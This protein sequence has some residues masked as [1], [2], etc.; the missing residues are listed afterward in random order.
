MLRKSCHSLTGSCDV[1]PD[2]LALQRKVR[3]LEQQRDD[4]WRA[5]DAAAREIEA[6]KDVLLDQV[7]ERLAQTVSE[8]YLFT[9]RFQIV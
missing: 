3:K 2:K 4:A 5:Y 8:E 1:I 6:Q 7:E 9:I